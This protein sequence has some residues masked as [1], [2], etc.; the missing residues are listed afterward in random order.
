[1]F[2]VRI[3][4]ERGVSVSEHGENWRSPTWH[5][6]RQALILDFGF[7]ILDWKRTARGIWAFY[8]GKANIEH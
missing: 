8:Y 7:L 3:L 2:G 4:F 1:M 6:R 5:G